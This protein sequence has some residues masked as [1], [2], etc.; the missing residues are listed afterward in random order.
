M[1]YEDNSKRP[2]VRRNRGTLVA[3][4]LPL[5]VGSSLTLISSK[6]DLEELPEDSWV[7]FVRVEVVK[8]ESNLRFKH[9]RNGIRKV[10][11]QNRCVNFEMIVESHR[12]SRRGSVSLELFHKVDSKTILKYA[13]ISIAVEFRSEKGPKDELECN[14][15]LVEKREEQPLSSV[16][17]RNSP[18]VNTLNNNN[19]SSGPSLRKQTLRNRK[20]NKKTKSIV[21]DEDEDV[22]S[23]EELDD[24]SEGAEEDQEPESRKQS[25]S[26]SST[27]VSNPSFTQVSYNPFSTN[28]STSTSFPSN[29]NFSSNTN[30]NHSSSFNNFSNFSLFPPPSV[31]NTPSQN[32]NP[33]TPLSDSSDSPVSSP[34]HIVP[35][36]PYLDSNPTTA[37][38]SPFFSSLPTSPC[39]EPTQSYP[40]KNTN[41]AYTE[42]DLYDSPIDPLFSTDDNF[43]FLSN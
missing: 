43:F 10:P 39:Y 42:F 30:N 20:P 33:Q 21:K 19:N 41:E 25:S 36:S 18:S 8:L 35:N 17:E 23:A 28:H 3:A 34:D 5:D 31:V 6:K 32:A 27:G 29:N 1:S 14:L 24:E 7:L 4:K 2:V 22:S 40:Q 11:I 12:T 26:S 9:S 15:E 38:S 13:E 37:P 16:S